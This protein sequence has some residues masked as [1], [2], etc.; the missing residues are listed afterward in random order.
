MKPA[1]D[2]FVML[3]LERLVPGQQSAKLIERCIEHCA[4]Y[5]GLSIGCANREKTRQ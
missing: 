3:L 5:R 1:S 2:A 4:S